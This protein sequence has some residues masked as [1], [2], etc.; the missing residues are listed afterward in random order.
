MKKL[1]LLAVVLGVISLSHS[2]KADDFCQSTTPILDL[3]CQ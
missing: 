2:T 3:T 1:I